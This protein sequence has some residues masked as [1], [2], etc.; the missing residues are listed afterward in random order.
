MSN[1]T[2]VTGWTDLFEAA[3][4]TSDGMLAIGFPIV[5]WVAIFGWSLG[6]NGRSEAL[7][8]ASFITLVL[9][10]FENLAGWIDFWVVIANL[11]LLALGIFMLMLERRAGG[12]S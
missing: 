1:F 4:T 9:T 12:G 2:N 5:V 7:V 3:N 10:F 8:S 6:T 11:I